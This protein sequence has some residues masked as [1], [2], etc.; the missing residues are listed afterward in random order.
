MEPKFIQLPEKKIVGLGTKFISILSPDKNN[1]STIPPLWQKF[2]RQ[3]SKIPHKAG[4]TCFGLVESLPGNERKSHKDEMFYVAG[5]EV[6]DFGAVPAGM[7]QRTIPA[8]RFA[9]FTFKGKLDGLEQTM[10]AIYGTWLPKSKV[11]LRD[12]AHLEFYDRR[13]IPGSDQSEF[14]ILLPVE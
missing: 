5:A 6:T 7:L 8:G 1:F 13:F 4:D 9:T 11:K 12:A 2:M 10:N 14:D 3:I